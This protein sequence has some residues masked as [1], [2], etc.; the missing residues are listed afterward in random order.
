MVRMASESSHNKID[1][2]RPDR[3][4][5]RLGW[6]RLVFA[7]FAS[8]EPWTRQVVCARWLEGGG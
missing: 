6:I 2:N 3:A 7:S 5:T 4:V 1:E 8:Q